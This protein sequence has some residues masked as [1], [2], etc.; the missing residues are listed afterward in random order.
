[1]MEASH[2]LCIKLP[3]YLPC[4]INA[5]YVLERKD[6]ENILVARTNGERTR[7]HFQDARGWRG[8]EAAVLGIAVE[9]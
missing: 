7:F 1:M 3:S 4:V 8:Q 5:P 9:I 2:P 6:H